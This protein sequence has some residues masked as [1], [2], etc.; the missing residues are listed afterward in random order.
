MNQPLRSTTDLT[1]LSYS[2]APVSHGMQTA[3]RVD[4]TP[5]GIHLVIPFTLGTAEFLVP[6]ADAARLLAQLQAAVG[7]NS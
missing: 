1:R 7:S 4:T 3:F 6:T 2:T 5:Q